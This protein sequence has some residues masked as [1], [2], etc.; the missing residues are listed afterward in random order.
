MLGGG[1]VLVAV[2]SR[3]LESSE[4]WRRWRRGGY[5][6]SIRVSKGCNAAIFGLVRG[7]ERRLPRWA[8]KEVGAAGRRTGSRVGIL[9]R[10]CEVVV[11]QV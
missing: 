2:S 8:N 5:C 10:R 11:V 3:C 1:V 9:K 6:K 7:L 4:G